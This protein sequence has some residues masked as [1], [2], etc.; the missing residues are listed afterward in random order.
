MHVECFTR[1]RSD[2]S[3]TSGSSLLKM[4]DF[5]VVLAALLSPDNETRNQAEV[6]GDLNT[7][8]ECEAHITEGRAKYIVVFG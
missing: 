7:V 5:Q 3:G 2:P 6:G 4:A 1:A 8:S